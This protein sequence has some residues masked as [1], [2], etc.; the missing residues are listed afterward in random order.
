MKKIILIAILLVSTF[1][2]AQITKVQGVNYKPISTTQRDGI[3][4]G[5]NDRLKIYNSTTSQWEEWNG[6]AWVA[7]ATGGGGGTSNHLN[8]SNI[9]LLTMKK[10]L[11]ALTGSYCRQRLLA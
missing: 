2:F 6:T 1:A 8:L 4:L 3:S 5:V 10:A 7:S 9:G 11:L